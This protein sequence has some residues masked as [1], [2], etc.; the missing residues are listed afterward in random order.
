MDDKINKKLLNKEMDANHQ[1]NSSSK[2]PAE[3]HKSDVI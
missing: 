2:D 3:D 1:P